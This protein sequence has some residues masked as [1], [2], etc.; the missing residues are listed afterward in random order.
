MRRPPSV[1]GTTPCPVADRGR[2]PCICPEKALS[3]NP[4]ESRKRQIEDALR[5]LGEG[6]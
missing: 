4:N 3:L 1:P 5:D 2:A 6:S